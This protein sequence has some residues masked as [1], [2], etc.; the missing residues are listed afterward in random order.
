MQKNGELQDCFCAQ[1]EWLGVANG[2]F[3]YEKRPQCCAAVFEWSL[4]DL[5]PEPTG[6]RLWCFR[7]SVDYVFAMPCGLGA[8]CLCGH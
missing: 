6:L 4:R 7:T 3:V 2:N 8:G 5:N 1:V